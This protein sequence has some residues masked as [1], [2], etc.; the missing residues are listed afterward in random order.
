MRPRE[1][2][3]RRR[4]DFRVVSEM[5]NSVFDFQ[6]YRTPSDLERD[7]SRITRVEDATAASKYKMTLRIPTLI[8]PGKLCRETLF[9]VDLDVAD[10]PMT[11]PGTWV[12]SKPIPWSPH[13]R[14]GSPICIGH[15][16]W[17]G[18]KGHV[19]LG[20]LVEHIAR[21]LNWDEKGRGP[22]YRGFNGDA[23]DYHKEH[24]H[25]RALD[26]QITYPTPP[27][28]LFGMRGEPAAAFEIVH[29]QR[30]D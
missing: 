10:Y 5:R 24:Y 8:G 26:S 19:T 18:R 14:E 27:A 11:E 17:L 15:E 23:I 9:G 12:I 25:G 22:G 7:R 29:H 2:A 1:L 16:F 3:E 13:F 21:M 28:W 4:F 20:D 6:A 30:P